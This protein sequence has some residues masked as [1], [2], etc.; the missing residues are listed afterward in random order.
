MFARLNSASRRAMLAAFR[1]AQ[2]C[3][4]DF[5]G[6]EHLLY[7]L[8]RD[9]D[10]PVAQLLRSAG[11]DAAELLGKVEIALW[12]HGETGRLEQFPLS[13]AL[14]RALTQAEVDAASFRHEL[15]GPYHLLL[16]LLHRADGEAAQLL[17]ANGIHRDYVRA[18]LAQL[19]PD[20]QGDYQVQASGRP[21][22]TSNKNATADELD[23]WLMPVTAYPTYEP[24]APAASDD[25]RA[26]EAQ[27]R[28]VQMALAV[29]AGFAAGH[30]AG[31]VQ[32][33][34]LVA[35]VGAFVSLLHS[36]AAGAIFGLLTGLL[37]IPIRHP[38]APDSAATFLAP[39]VGAILGT[40]LG[41]AWRPGRRD[42]NADNSSAADR[43]EE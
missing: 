38:L 21:A 10:G 30:W 41:D 18:A 31:G 39:F 34:A 1:E 25:Q 42:A 28:R 43:D 24:P 12:R 27:L 6:T 5:V 23:A 35:I 7:G 37:M 22:L 29:V 4:H 15:V 40:F 8:L 14:K 33:G 36:S 16:G 2:R 3:Q 20:Q 13:P 32:I 9:T 26:I 19:P 17:V 11:G